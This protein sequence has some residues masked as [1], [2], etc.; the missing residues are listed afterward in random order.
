MIKPGEVY[1]TNYAFDVCSKKPDIKNGG[2]ENHSDESDTVRTRKVWTKTIFTIL[3]SEFVVA[4][5]CTEPLQFMNMEDQDRYIASILY[6]DGI[7]WAEIPVNFL[8][9]LEKIV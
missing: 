6:K 3:T 4:A 7:W 5:S 1:I 9:W 8:H 2:Y